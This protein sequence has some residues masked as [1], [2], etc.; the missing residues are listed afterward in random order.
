[1]NIEYKKIDMMS[2]NLHTIKTD[3]FKTITIRVCLRD[4]IKKEEITLRNV[5]ASF[6]TYSTEK[7]P[8]KRELALKAQDLYAVNVYTKSYR[9]GKFNMINFCMS[10]LNEKYTEKGM[11]EESIKFLSEIVFHPNFKN[12]TCFNEAFRYLY[13]S[14]ANSMKEIKENP[15]TYSVVRMLEEMDSNMPYGYREFG[16]MEDLNTLTKDKLIDYYNNVINNSLVDIY[17]IGNIDSNE[18][19]KL[20]KNY[21][22]FPTYKRPKELQLIEHDK[23]SSKIKTV[24]EKIEG[25]QSKL[26]IGCKIG[27]LTEFERNYVLTVYNMILGGN[28]E[29]KF[30]QIIRE[31]NSLAYYVYS[32]LNKLDSLMIIKAGISK[33]NYQKTIKLIKK[34]MKEM[35]LGNFT[36]EHIQVVKENYLS[37]LKEIEDNETAIIETYLAKDL[38]NLGNIEERKKEIMKVTKKDIISVAKKIKI[39]TIFLLEGVTDNENNCA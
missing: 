30:F 22:S 39:D 13:D 34:L 19:E 14:V 8:T 20:F 16:Y 33:E 17:V 15:T 28:S 37:L 35:E 1:M 25:N 9:S 36:D 11:L 18:I 31:Q 12:D 7:Y 3:R 2:F 6:L 4:K 10:M 23:L 27:S 29:S 24:N 32:S 26:S 38:L 21:F 5:L